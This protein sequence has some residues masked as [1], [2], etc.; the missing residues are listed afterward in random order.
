MKDLLKSKNIPTDKIYWYT[1]YSF[2]ID[3]LHGVDVH[4]GG[5][6]LRTDMKIHPRDKIRIT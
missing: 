6:P 5:V 4:I 2:L 1:R 3:N